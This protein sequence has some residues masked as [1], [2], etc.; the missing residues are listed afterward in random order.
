MSTILGLVMAFV[1]ALAGAGTSTIARPRWPGQ[2]PGKVILGMSCGSDCAARQREL[3]SPYGVHRDFEKWAD[4]AG[5]L[6]VIR[7]DHAQ[8]R[9]PWVSVEGPIQGTPEGWK[10]VAAGT[11]DA[12]IRQLAAAIVSSDDKPILLT[13]N[14]E[15]SNDGTEAQ[16][17]WW[18][19][20]FTHFCDVLEGAGALANT[21]CVPILGDWLFNPA[22]KKQVP[23]HW[24]THAVLR[25][26]AF[27]GV[28]LYENASGRPMGPRLQH[29][30]DW[31]AAQGFPDKMVGVGE[32]GTTDAIH[33]GVTSVD[34]LNES[35]SWAKA[36]PDKIGVIS[37]FNSTANSRAGA[38]WP[39]DEDP[40]KIRTF[41][42]WLA[43]GTFVR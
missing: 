4:W 9:L 5:V 8:G 36:N 27:L 18:A 28:D 19:A 41:R 33:P 2:Q 39:L 24:V 7:H 3:G 12:E 20:A 1:L 10:A 26:A 35:L 15:P 6:A 11:Y 25:R 21:G 34:Y 43:D 42:K 32:L 31:M 17:A 13:F 16:G 30:I 37:Y 22:N 14:H 29:I 23:S 38:Y 40:A